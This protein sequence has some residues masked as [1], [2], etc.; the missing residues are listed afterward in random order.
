MFS[1]SN[2]ALAR[3]GYLKRDRNDW[4]KKRGQF[5]KRLKYIIKPKIKRPNITQCRNLFFEKNLRFGHFIL[6]LIQKGPKGLSGPKR[7]WPFGSDSTIWSSGL[8][9][10][11]LLIFSLS[12]YFGLFKNRS[13]FF[14]LNEFRLIVVQSVKQAKSILFLPADTC[15]FYLYHICTF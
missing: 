13:R 14:R 5:F 12:I 1:R 4:Q 15:V 2:T 7:V 6:G 8:L 3:S 9:I 10:L 11:G